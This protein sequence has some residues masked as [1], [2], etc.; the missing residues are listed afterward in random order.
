MGE[1]GLWMTQEE[2]ESGIKNEIGITKYW[3]VCK[4]PCK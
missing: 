2:E 1:H 4:M 3:P